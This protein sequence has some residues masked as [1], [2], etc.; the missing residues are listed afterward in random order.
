MDKRATLQRFDI[1]AA[2]VS[3]IGAIVAGVW[4]EEGWLRIL[5]TAGFVIAFVACAVKAYRTRKR[6]S[7]QCDNSNT[8]T[9]KL[10][11]ENGQGI[12]DFDL[13]RKISLLI[14]KSMFDQAVDIDLSSSAFASTIENAHAV[15][16]YANGNW[17]LEDVS[18]NGEVSLKKEGLHYRLSKDEPC[19]LENGDIIEIGC[20]ELQFM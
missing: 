20:A 2:I 17:Y 9:V 4:I 10:L 15:L 11:D 13:E 19:V 14:G 1:A 8:H 12:F 3:F 6:F 7:H 16:N 5:L 18:E